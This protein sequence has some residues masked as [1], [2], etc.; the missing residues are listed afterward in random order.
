MRG[1]RWVLVALAVAVV[2]LGACKDGHDDESAD[3]PDTTAPTAE[4]TAH[5]VAAWFTN[6][7]SPN[8]LQ[9]T[10]AEAQCA[11]QGVVDGLGV[12]RIEELRSEAANEVGSTGDGVDLL[13]EPPL[14]PDEAD[15]VYTAMTGCIDFTAQVTDVLV[16]AGKPPDAARCMAERYVETDVPR[17]AIMAAETDPELMAEINAALTQVATACAG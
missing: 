14:E 17:R 9:F 4:E 1:G 3:P 10:S 6:P 16:A 7:S 15:V 2:P 11:A 12:A 8:G 13:Q 5:R